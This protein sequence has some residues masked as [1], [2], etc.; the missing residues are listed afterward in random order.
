M[1][2]AS[3]PPPA[4]AL[5]GTA[6]HATHAPLED[7]T[8]RMLAAS[9]FICVI[10]ATLGI[11]GTFTPLMT[12]TYVSP[13]FTLAN[14]ISYQQTCQSC[15][16]SNPLQCASALPTGNI[17]YTNNPISSSFGSSQLTAGLSFSVMAWILEII[18]LPAIIACVAETTN[19]ALA[20]GAL[21]R[22]ARL[23]LTT[24]LAVFAVVFRCI[25]L[26]CGLNYVFSLLLNPSV[27]PGVT[28]SSQ[29]NAGLILS[30]IALGFSAILVVL[31]WWA[32]H[33]V[34]YA[35]HHPA[36]SAVVAHVDR[37]EPTPARV[38]HAV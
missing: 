36:K 18:A 24:W 33:N 29:S 28:Y 12:G 30:F 25:A 35:I 9:F 32:Q 19:S 38:L 5:A 23:P 27:G 11:A 26:G 4:S 13:L 16:S 15:T 1:S 3:A 21:L 34:K 8:H 7:A 2:S 14:S 10:A 17:C 6:A 22:A 20:S 37:L 31:L